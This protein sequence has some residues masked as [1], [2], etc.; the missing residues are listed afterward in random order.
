MA[1]ISA[2]HPHSLSV[3]RR[4]PCPP[5]LAPFSSLVVSIMAEATWFTLDDFR[6]DARIHG[7]NIDVEKREVYI[8]PIEQAFEQ[9]EAT[10]SGS[11]LHLRFV[12]QAG[13]NPYLRLEQRPYLFLPTPTGDMI[14]FVAKMR[15]GLKHIYL[16]AQTKDAWHNIEFW[17]MALKDPE[18]F[19][20][21]FDLITKHAPAGTVLATRHP[22]PNASKARSIKHK[23]SKTKAIRKMMEEYRDCPVN[24]GKFEVYVHEPLETLNSREAFVQFYARVL[25]FFNQF[26]QMITEAAETFGGA[27][28]KLMNEPPAEEATE[29]DFEDDP[30]EPAMPTLIPHNLIF[31]GPP[32][33]GKTHRTAEEVVRLLDPTFLQS[34]TGVPPR[35]RYGRLKER[36]EQLRQDKRVGFVT[37]HQ[38]FSYED[39]VEGIRARTVDGQIQYTEEKGVFAAL[40]DRALQN[41]TGE[42]DLGL[43]PEARVWKISLEGTGPSK[44]REYCLKHG[45]IRVGWPEVGSF[46]AEER[47][48]EEEEAYL[49]L[50]SNNQNSI[51]YF[52]EGMQVGDVVVCMAS[53]TTVQAVGVITGPYQHEDA[54]PEGVDPDYRNVRKVRWWVK[55]VQLDITDLNGQAALSQV[56]LYSLKNVQVPALVEHLRTLGYLKLQQ[57][58]P[59]QYALVIDEINRG[60]IS[61]VFGELI[62]L[63]EPSKR[64]GS[65]EAQTVT[66]PYSKGDFVVPPNLHV[67]GTMNTADKSLTRLDIALRR[68]FTFIEVPPEP[69]LLRTIRVKGVDINLK[70]FLF[71]IN[72]RIELLFD[73]DHTLGHAYLMHLGEDST[74]EDLAETMQNRILPL[75]Q[76]YFFD[77]WGNIRRVLR[78]HKAPQDQQFI[79]EDTSNGQTWLEESRP[80]TTYRVNLEALTNPQSYTK[81][82]AVLDESHFGNL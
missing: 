21:C 47:T 38:S 48:A 41:L 74:I 60:N 37:F 7:P 76:E 22:A 5:P 16:F 8:T 15:I 68:R 50:K 34:L 46:V 53:K 12:K 77:N 36:Y 78:D 13:D 39:F 30:E 2:L 18:W 44:T 80:I 70:R 51:E 79:L 6:E 69:E 54:A 63:L 49:Q 32:G 56:T 66:L 4:P 14:V 59:L 45:E 75:L 10:Q 42:E 19:E 1:A 40:A 26:T 61:R 24:M 52:A 11:T 25:P 64:Y 27:P 58:E 65:P 71:A 55:G 33:T 3:L 29:D 72:K 67:I 23:A 9:V 62:T 81:V 28:L 43:R 82:Y 31:Y 20:R 57:G 35:E 17:K 73:R